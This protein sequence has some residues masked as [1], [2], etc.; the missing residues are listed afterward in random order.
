MLKDRL[1]KARVAR[2][3]SQTEL[4]K[5]INVSQVA[6]QRLEAGDVKSTTFLVELATALDV[7][8]N[9]L[10]HGISPVTPDQKTV[11]QNLPVLTMQ[12]VLPYLEEGKLPDNYR[13]VPMLMS[14]VKISPKTFS[15]EI[16]GDAMVSQQEP[17]KSMFPGELAV[18]DPDR[19]AK[20]GDMVLA[21]I[22]S[23]DLK[24]RQ[25]MKDGSQPLLKAL[26][27]KYNH[28]IIG[29]E[30]KILGVV[31]AALKY[32]IPPEPQSA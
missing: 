8:P 6:I 26:S 1:K 27:D 24:I 4:A 5:R 30:T 32:F 28:I 18:I 2:G 25:Y 21:Q 11:V 10:L 7:S 15:M 23:E 13:S 16:D 12:D 20:I 19:A 3:L 17:S 9:W 31:V 29:E 14:S 22:T